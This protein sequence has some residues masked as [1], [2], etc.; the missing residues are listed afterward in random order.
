MAQA[1]S[2]Q[3]LSKLAAPRMLGRIISAGSFA[4]IFGYALVFAGYGLAT[5]GWV[6]GAFYLLDHVFFAMQIALKT[7][8]QKIADPADISP[9]AGGAFSIS[10]VAA[11]AIPIGFGVIWLWSA[12]A[13]F[14]LGA[15]MAGLSL[16]LALM[17]PRHP[18]PGNEVIS[19]GARL[20]APAE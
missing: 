7:Y 1:L 8:F 17:V 4:A 16:M 2:L 20:P 19:F 10:H 11:I 12:T 15:G 3:W 5:S 18:E 14:K 6:A 9:T 13:V